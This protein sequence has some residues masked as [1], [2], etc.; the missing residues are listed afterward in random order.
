MSRKANQVTETKMGRRPISLSNEQIKELEELGKT[1]NIEQIAD[2][3]GISERTF[4]R[5]RETN[6]GVLTAY[7][8][9]KANVINQ[10]AKKLIEKALEGDTPSIIFF[11]KTQ[12]GWS[13]KQIQE[14]TYNGVPPSL[15][16][17]ANEK[18][19]HRQ[20]G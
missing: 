17:I 8:K 10:I 16:L 20:E 12:A 7:K 19:S 18:P 9:G 1:M 3:F 15:N 6:S 2:Y 13:E 4:L 11:L 14:V 5:L